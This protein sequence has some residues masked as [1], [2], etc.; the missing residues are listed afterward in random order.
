MLYQTSLQATFSFFPFFLWNSFVTSGGAQRL[1]TFFKIK[2]RSEWGAGTAYPRVSE[3]L[4]SCGGPKIQDVLYILLYI[5][6][7]DT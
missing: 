5:L 3:Y 7:F 1:Y 4:L 2:P 6:A